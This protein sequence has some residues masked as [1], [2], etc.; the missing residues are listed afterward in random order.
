[1]TSLSRLIV[2]HR[3]WIL[4]PLSFAEGPITAFVAGTLAS[5]GYFNIFALAALFLVRDIAV[6]L[7]CY[8]LGY[9][10]GQAV[11][12]RRLLA[13]LGVADEALRQ[14]R[15][16]WHAHPGKTMFLS[17]LSYGVAGGFIVAAGLVRVPLPVFLEYAS[18]VAVLHYGVL[19]SAGYFFG[20]T[21]GGSLLAI[22]QNVPRAIAGLS[23]LAIAY[24]L[25]KRRMSRSLQEEERKV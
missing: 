10:G 25:L 24:Y 19:L 16:L 3:Y 4:L 15:A 5:A 18:A 13:C 6:D 12:V 11:W 1:M 21:S 14:V 17:K 23:A 22:L 9:V 8:V 7:A 20:E 2:D